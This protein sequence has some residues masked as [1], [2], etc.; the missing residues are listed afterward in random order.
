MTFTIPVLTYILFICVLSVSKIER[1]RSCRHH[2]FYTEYMEKRLF[3]FNWFS[4]YVP[5][6]YWFCTINIYNDKHT[7]SIRRRILQTHPQPFGKTYRAESARLWMWNQ[8]PRLDS[9][10]FHPFVVLMI[11]DKMIWC[12]FFVFYVTFYFYLLFSATFWC[13]HIRRTMPIKFQLIL[14]FHALS[15]TE[16]KINHLTANIRKYE[17]THKFGSVATAIIKFHKVLWIFFMLVLYYC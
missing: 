7:Y 2:Q 16:H 11:Y 1:N 17:I 14:R 10:C 5:Y 6:E 3:F 13:L 4:A 8:K 15:T 9:L 12:F